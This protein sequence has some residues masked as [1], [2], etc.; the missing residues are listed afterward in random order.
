[1]EVSIEIYVSLDLT[2][3]SPRVGRKDSGLRNVKTYC[4]GLSRNHVSVRI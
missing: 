3:A 1:M 4:F 2:L